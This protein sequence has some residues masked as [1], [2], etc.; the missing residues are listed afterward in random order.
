LD[1]KTPTHLAHGKQAEIIARKFLTASGLKLVEKNFSTKSGEI[2]LIMLDGKCMVFVEVRYRQS[3]K[4]GLPQETV[5]RSKQRKI[6][7]AAQQYLI[8]KRLSD[9]CEC[10]FDIVAIHGTIPNH[11]INWITHAFYAQT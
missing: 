2:D 7:K 10:R 5:I 4:F 11:N 1:S 3:T 9:Q 6:T 8:R